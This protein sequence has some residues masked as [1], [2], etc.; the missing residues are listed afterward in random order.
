MKKVVCVLGSPRS[1][2][3]SETIAQKLAETAES[4]GAQSRTFRLNDLNLKGCQGCMGCKTGSEV[5]VVRDDLAPVLAAVAGADVVVLTSPIYFGQI[6][7]QL[8]SFIDRTFSY[9]QPDF[10]SNPNPSR[11][12]PGKKMVFI[13][14][15]GDNDLKNYDVVP[16]YEG[17]YKT[18]GFETFSI[19]AGGLGA[20]TDAAGRP[21][22]MKQ[23]EELA[24]AVLA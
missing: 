6:S 3:N 23:A 1:G 18:M 24:K 12:A 2:G 22:L 8:K 5:C 16:G 17:A 13:V 7:G 9:L 20:P 4:L 11:L 21:D 15:Q 14:T 10:F 19:R